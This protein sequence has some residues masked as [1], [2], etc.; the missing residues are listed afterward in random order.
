VDRDVSTAK[1][2][3]D[4]GELY[5]FSLDDLTDEFEIRQ[6]L[7]APHTTTLESISLSSQAFQNL[8]AAYLMVCVQFWA[9]NM[10]S[11]KRAIDTKF[12][13]VLK[14]ARRIGLMKARHELDDSLDECLWINKESQIR[15]MNIITL[16]DCALSF[17]AN[18]PCRLTVSEMRFDL[19]CEETLFSSSHPFSEPKFTPSRHLTTYEAFQSLF[20]QVKPTTISNQGKKGNPLGLNPMDMFILV[21]LLYVYAHTHVTLFSSSLPRTP[22]GSGISTPTGQSVSSSDSNVVLIRAALSRW[23]SLWTTIRSNIP[24]HA[25]ASLGFYR[26]GYNYWLV[27]QLLINNKGSVDVMM[28]MEVGCEDTLKQLKGLLRDGGNDT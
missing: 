5:V 18:F 22:E 1:V 21:H 12:G 10:V 9:G 26:N 17:F 24:S 2:L 4:L 20:G 14:V 11:R 25:W 16:L 15:L 6:M 7:R 23:R 3:L 19:P 8:Q 27:T 13:V 28:G